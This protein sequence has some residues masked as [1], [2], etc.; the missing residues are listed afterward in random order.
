MRQKSPL[1]KV[2]R[3]ARV[4]AYRLVGLQ[5]MI[6]VV[7]ALGWWWIKGVIEGLSVLLG[8]MACLLP[9]LYFA[10]CLFATTSPPVVK[11][12]MVS[13]YLGEVIKLALSAGMVIVI[14]LYISVSI[15]PFIM[16][17]VGAQLGFWLAALVVKLDLN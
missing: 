15:V 12:S 4:I 13:F 3:S 11:Q 9:S 14:I 16:G 17:F 7:V 10:H 2:T 6:V 1:N 5:A 8:G